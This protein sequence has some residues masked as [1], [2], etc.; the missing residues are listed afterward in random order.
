[1]NKNKLLLSTYII[2]QIPSLFFDSKFRLNLSIL[3][4]RSTRIDFFAMY[5]ANAVN[6][7]IMAYCLHYNKEISK[8]VTMFILA[9]TSLDMIH[10]MLFAKQGFGMAKIGLAI[11]ILGVYEWRFVVKTALNAWEFVVETISK[12]WNKLKIIL[13]RLQKWLV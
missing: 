10:L 12:L 6:F 9:I 7:L 11:L 2:S 5:Y 4:E 3:V 8:T 13:K 1:M